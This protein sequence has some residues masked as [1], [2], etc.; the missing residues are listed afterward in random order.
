VN[1]SPRFCG[2]LA[3]FVLFI[4]TP[5]LAQTQTGTISGTVAGPDG[6]LLPG[7]TVTVSGPALMGTRTYVTDAAG[8]FRHQAL[9]PGRDYVVEIALDNFRTKRLE[10]VLVQA[11]LTTTLP[12]ELALANV[13]AEVIVE[14]GSPIIDIEQPVIATNFGP[15]ILGNIPNSQRD[16]GQTVLA[17][18]GIVDGSKEN[19]YGPMYGSRGG[20][21][22]ANQAAVDGVINTAPCITFRRAA[23]PCSRASR[24]CRSSPARSRP[25]SATWAA[26]T[27]T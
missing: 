18:P 12:V 26:P 2:A 6:A 4:V 23:A 22:I 5:L 14:R 19:Y 17:A 20:S 11:G 24:K 9:P 13:S 3:L 8:N 25:R 27:S 15:D 7:A 10:G 21:V 16:W 1:S